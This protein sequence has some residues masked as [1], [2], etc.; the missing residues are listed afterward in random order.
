[1]VCWQDE[2]LKKKK[3]KKYFFFRE[4]PTS[5]WDQY[6]AKFRPLGRVFRPNRPQTEP[7]PWGGANT[8]HSTSLDK[9]SQAQVGQFVP[10]PAPNL[11]YPTLPYPTLPYLTL[12]LTLPYPTLP[13]I[14]LPLPYPTPPHPNPPRPGQAHPYPY[15][16]PPTLLGKPSF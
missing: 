16:T 6:R 11:P 12:T 10:Y 14:T 9:P 3:K 8:I 15:P 1:M 2:N 13:Y 7:L 5:P 4:T